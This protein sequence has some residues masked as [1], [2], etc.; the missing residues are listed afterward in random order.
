MKQICPKCKKE[1]IPLKTSKKK[2]EGNLII[3]NLKEVCPECNFIITNTEEKEKA[4]I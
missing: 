3:K 2:R 4:V 1:I